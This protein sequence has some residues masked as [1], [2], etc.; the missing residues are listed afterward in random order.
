M[1]NANTQ[2]YGTKQPHYNP[3]SREIP[4]VLAMFVIL[5]HGYDFWLAD[6]ISE[7]VKSLSQVC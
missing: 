7:R 6:E 5:P 2:Y 4:Y 3:E 1:Y